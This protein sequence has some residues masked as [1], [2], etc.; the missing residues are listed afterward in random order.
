MGKTLVEKLLSDKVGHDVVP[1]ETVIVDLDFVGLHDASGPLAVR[2]M[3]EKGWDKIFDPKR[4]MFCTEF[5]PSSNRELSNEHTLIR[6]FAKRHGCYWH[7]GGTGNIHTHLLENYVNCGDIIVAGDSH[8]TTH[9]A[10]GAF[11]TGMGSTDMVGILKLGKTWLK[12]PSSYLVEVNGILQKGV[13]SK[14][15]FLYLLSQ[16]GTEDAIYKALEF[17]GTTIASLSMDARFT[18]CNMGVEAGAKVAIMETDE[19]TKAFLESFGRHDAYREIKADKD[20]KYE[21][22]ISIDAS[23]LEPLVAQPHYPDN[24]DKIKNI[25]KVKVDQVFLGSCTNGRIED[26]HIAA[27]IL[28]GKKIQE[29]VRLVVIPNSR[30]VF[31]DC[32]KDGTF[33][34]LGEAGA[35]ILSP[36]CGPCMGVHEGIPADNEVVVSTQNRNFKGR[37]GNPES[38]VYLASP[39]TAAASALTGYLTDPREVL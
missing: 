1:G 15:I 19:H 36:N 27:K 32:I 18:I 4:V 17:R 22:K 29:W 33:E 5:G 28:S 24:V 8:M 26:M 16:I 20:A 12:V 9:G 13:Y 6:E 37:M 2:L 38:F 7:E 35:M 30:R 11:A 25:E 10:L 34:I 23:D 3:K 39:A 14:D 21:K 31:L